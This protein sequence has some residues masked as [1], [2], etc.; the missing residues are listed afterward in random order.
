MPMSDEVEFAE[1]GNPDSMSSNSDKMK[2]GNS[3]ECQDGNEAVIW[4]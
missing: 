1:S 4:Q 2:S 3:D